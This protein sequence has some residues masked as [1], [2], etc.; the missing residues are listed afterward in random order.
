MQ[1]SVLKSVLSLFAFL[2]ILTSCDTT[3]PFRFVPPDFSTVPEPFDYNEVEPIVIEPGIEAYILEE[4]EGQ[5]FVTLRD[6]ISMLVTLRTLDGEVIYSSFIDGNI[7]PVSNQRVDLIRPN[8]SVLNPRSAQML[9]TDGL[10][11]GLAGMKAGEIRTLI[12]SPEQGFG[13]VTGGLTA[14]YSE[15]ILQYDIELLSIVN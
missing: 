9:Y 2:I 12:V 10:R 6:Q 13:S 5:F 7:L 3:D 4:G 8:S 14:Q 15:S 1:T 11:K